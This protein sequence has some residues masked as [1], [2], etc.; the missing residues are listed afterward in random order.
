MV[1]FIIRINYKTTNSISK[2]CSFSKVKNPINGWKAII[3]TP[4]YNS[5]NVRE[6]I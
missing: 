6:C 3:F 4:D 5:L 2:N 1:K